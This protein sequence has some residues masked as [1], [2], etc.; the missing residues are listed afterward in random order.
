[1]CRSARANA[2]LV[3]FFSARMMDF[4]AKQI[5]IWRSEKGENENGI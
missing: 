4:R 1:L 2:M 5:G 3:L